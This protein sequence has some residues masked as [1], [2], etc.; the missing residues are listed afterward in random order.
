V[1]AIPILYKEN[2]K[3]IDKKFILNLKPYNNTMTLNNNEVIKLND[4]RSF[5]NNLI[6]HS[7]LDRNLYLPNCLKSIINNE[8]NL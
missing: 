1:K 2:L 4:S 5:K 7:V 8:N 3:L 6:M